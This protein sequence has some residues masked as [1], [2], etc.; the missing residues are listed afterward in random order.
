MDQRAAAFA[1]LF[2]AAHEGVFIGTLPLDTRADGTTVAA[3]PHLKLMFGVPA[4]TPE[5]EVAPLAANRF[6]DPA[7]RTVFVDRLVADGSVT[8]YLLR[9][10]RVDGTPLWVEITAHAT[11]TA[12]SDLHIEALLRDVSERKRTHDRDRDLYQQLLQAEKMAALGQTISGVAHELNNPLATILSWAERLTALTSDDARRGV[13]VILG[14][15]ER[16]ARIVRNLLTFAHKRQSTRTMVDLNRIVTETLAL[17]AYGQ[18]LANVHVVTELAPALPEVFADGHQIQQV[19][20]NLVINAE[21]AMLATNGHGTLTVRTA[22][23]AEQDSVQL[24]VSDDG[25]G[26]PPEMESKIFDPFFTTKE[27]GKGTGLGLTVAYAIVQEHGGRIRVQSAALAGLAGGTPTPG[28]AFLVELPVSLPQAPSR[29]PRPLSSPS[30]EAVR[31]SRIMLV[32]DERA[33]ATAVAEALTDAGL[34]IDHASD[35]EEAFARVRQGHYDAVICDLKMPRVDGMMLYRAIAAATPRLA[36][37]VIFV[38]GDVAG[39]DAE[40]FLDE[41]GCRWLAKPFRLVDL[42]V[43]LRDVLA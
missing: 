32:E 11:I 20:L 34:Q 31:G 3:N 2:E 16:A 41:S 15:A 43:T 6:A 23:D 10:R 37:R 5:R 33:L 14:E 19:L 38:T 25:P 29:P 30:M 13:T 7:A 12:S 35:G 1:R 40:R 28:A 26:V 22:H 27:V 39:T 9:L 42:L 21:Q 4:S 18:R 8:D 36:R 24:M 17:R